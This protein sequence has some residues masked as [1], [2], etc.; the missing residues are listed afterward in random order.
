[1][2]GQIRMWV[3]EGIDGWN[4]EWLDELWIDECVDR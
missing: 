1:M 3:E 4:G 2:D